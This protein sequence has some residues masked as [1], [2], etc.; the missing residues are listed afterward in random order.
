MPRHPGW[1]DKLAGIVADRSGATDR[2][3]SGCRC[4]LGGLAEHCRVWLVF[5]LRNQAVNVSA[6]A[7]A[8]AEEGVRVV[9]IDVGCREVRSPRIIGRERGLV[10]ESV[11]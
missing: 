1:V 7:V 11:Q 6:P 2:V 8:I 10:Q 3:S 9:G 5:V 4:M